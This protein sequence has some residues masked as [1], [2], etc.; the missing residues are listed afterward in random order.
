METTSFK[1]ADRKLEDLLERLRRQNVCGCCAAR[2]LVF[3][4]AVLL[5]ETA[6]T[7]EAIEILE[8][9]LA[10]LRTGPTVPPSSS[11]PSTEAH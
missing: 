5:E 6:G 7:A 10:S 8:D 4:G 3:R 1:F 2:A 9:V 11:M